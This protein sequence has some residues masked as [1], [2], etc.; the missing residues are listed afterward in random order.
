[1][2]QI[3]HPSAVFSLR[4]FE[5]SQNDPK[6]IDLT[7]WKGDYDGKN[8]EVCVAN[9]LVNSLKTLFLICNRHI[10]VHQIAN[11]LRQNRVIEA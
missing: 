7:R 5:P 2:L 10:A 9:F 3:D 1:M 8:Q 6:W 4:I 11:P